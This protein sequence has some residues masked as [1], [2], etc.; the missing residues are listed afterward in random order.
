MVYSYIFFTNVLRILDERHMTRSELSERSGISNS[1]L[2]DLAK[3]KANPSLK[4]MVAIASALETP[5]P[6]LL[7]SID[8]ERDTL[9]SLVGGK[10]PDAMTEQ[11]EFDSIKERAKKKLERDMGAGAACRAE[12]PQDRR[13]HA[14]C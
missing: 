8:W 11:K 9:D 12:R 14:Q 13:N 5:L 6:L 2:S 10:M 1:F 3:G 7:E 4:V